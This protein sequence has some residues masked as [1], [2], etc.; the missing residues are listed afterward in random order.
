MSVKG[1]GQGGRGNKPGSHRKGAA[2]GSGGLAKRRLEGK[3][4]TP[5]AEVRKGHPKARKAAAAAKR[6]ATPTKGGATARPGR[7]GAPAKARGTKPNPD[8]PETVV[9]RNP[10]VEALRAKVPATALY[11]AHG[12]DNDER[13]AEALAIAGK[14]GL[15]IIESSRTQLDKMTGGMLHQGLALQVPPYVYLHPD[16]LLARALE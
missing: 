16:D 5:P 7:S 12:A 11:I 15:A 8:L 14:A 3:G 1:G 9:G 10:V 13:M 4:P 2:T 6:A